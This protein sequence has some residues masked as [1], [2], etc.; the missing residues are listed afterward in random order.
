MKKKLVLCGVITACLL[1]LMITLA[2]YCLFG[3]EKGKAYGQSVHLS[4]EGEDIANELVELRTAT[5]RWHEFYDTFFV[6]SELAEYFR[7]RSDEVVEYMTTDEKGMFRLE[8]HAA[9]IEIYAYKGAKQYLAM[10]ESLSPFTT[11]PAKLDLTE[12]DYVAPALFYLSSFKNES[13]QEATG[14][15]SVG[16]QNC[17]VVLE[18]REKYKY[19]FRYFDYIRQLRERYDILYVVVKSENSEVALVDG[20]PYEI[21]I[22]ESGVPFLRFITIVDSLQET[23]NGYICVL[24][25]KDRTFDVVFRPEQIDW[26]GL[27][28]V[29]GVSQYIAPKPIQPVTVEQLRGA[30][31]VDEPAATVILRRSS[32]YTTGWKQRSREIAGAKQRQSRL[33]RTRALRE[34]N[35]VYEKTRDLF[36][37]LRRH[38]ILFLLCSL[39]FIVPLVIRRILSKQGGRE[40]NDG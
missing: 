19:D 4:Y 5:H 24:V 2:L 32:E 12:D 26:P 18:T 21:R 34:E 36:S 35:S 8:G 22:H 29:D 20:I 16:N 39:P 9:W 31:G 40:G 15:A 10:S 1:F 28:Q 23:E 7:S 30:K 37:F 25:P 13:G 27:H 17:V 6:G 14:R 38:W 11:I 3:Y 33:E